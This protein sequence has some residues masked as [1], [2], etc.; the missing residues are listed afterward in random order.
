MSLEVSIPRIQRAAWQLELLLVVQYANHGH[1]KG[2][3]NPLRTFSRPLYALLH[4]VRSFS[5]LHFVPPAR[6]K[7][8]DAPGTRHGLSCALHCCGIRAA[9]L[10]VT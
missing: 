8:V 6:P 10:E 4:P 9:N 7:E 5:G 1:S 3:G 2:L